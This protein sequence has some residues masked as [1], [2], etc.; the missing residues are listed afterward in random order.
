M[1][2][3]IA[4]HPPAPCHPEQP[5]YARNLCYHCYYIAYQKPFNAQRMRRRYAVK[6]RIKHLLKSYGITQQAFNQ[7]LVKQHNSCAICK[8]PFTEVPHVDH[9]HKNNK[10]RGLLC[11]SCNRGIG[12]FK[13]DLTRLRAA[14]VYLQEHA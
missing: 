10:H 9:N 2:S 3:G 5:Y 8:S 1:P 11:G 4:G 13:D 12:M 6:G 7:L 14:I